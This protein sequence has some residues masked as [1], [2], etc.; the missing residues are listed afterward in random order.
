MINPTISRCVKLGPL[1]MSF[2]WNQV[3]PFQVE[4]LRG[5]YST[6]FKQLTNAR[7][8]FK[9]ASTNNR[10][11][12]SDVEALRAKVLLSLNHELKSGS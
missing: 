9:D 7:Q 3:S 11:L 5:E 8:Q 1:L 12:K 2:S 10:V 6:L 4:Q